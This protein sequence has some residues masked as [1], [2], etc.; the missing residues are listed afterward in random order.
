MRKAEMPSNQQIA[1]F[2]NPVDED[3]ITTTGL[4][5]I[6]G[7]DL[8]EQDI[9]DA[10]VEEQTKKMYH[11]ILN[12]SAAKQLGWS[13]QEAVGKKMFLDDSRPGYVRGVVRDFHF[14]S[15]HQAIRPVILFPESWSM[16]LLLKLSGHHLPQTIAFLESKWK[17]LVP[18]RPFEYKFLDEDY[19]NLYHSEQRL[20]AIMNISAGIAMV[21]ACFGLFGLSAYSAQQRVKEMG[22]RKVLGASLGQI[23]FVMSKD[24]IRLVLMSIA[25]AFPL[26]WFAVH[27]WLQDFAYKAD[28]S[29]L[30]F[31]IAAM[32]T[33]FLAIATISFQ[34]LKTG[35]ANPVKSLRTE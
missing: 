25:I 16:Q 15:L 30:S 4:Q 20:G 7:S 10:S 21:L 14:Q 17:R 27:K 1:V 35:L 33:V 23:A 13:A 19:N 34:A 9:A 18:N 26:A 24:F 8:T 6:A 29:W 12:E 3:F 11:F 2:A 32:A 31:V 28:I 5:L 22:I